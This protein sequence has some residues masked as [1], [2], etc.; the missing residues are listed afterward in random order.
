[1]KKHVMH[2]QPVLCPPTRSQR[3]VEAQ[4]SELPGNQSTKSCRG[5]FICAKNNPG[6]FFPSF[7]VLCYKQIHNAV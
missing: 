2:P 3:L 4:L 6:S 7:D 5:R 1:M